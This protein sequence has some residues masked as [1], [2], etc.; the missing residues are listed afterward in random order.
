MHLKDNIVFV[1][2]LNRGRFPFSNSLLVKGL[3]KT[4]L[5]DVGAGFDVLIRLKDRVDLVVITHLHVDHFSLSYLFKGKKV[6]VPAVE[7]KYRKLVDLAYRYLSEEMVDT[8][9]DFVRRVVGAGDPYFTDVYKEG[10]VFDLGGIEVQP[11]HAPGHTA[12]HHVMLIDNDVVYGADIDLTSFGPWY[13]HVESSIEEFKKSI[14]RVMELKPKIYVSGHKAP[15]KGRRKIL[16]ELEKY[17]EKFDETRMKILKAL[18]EP[19]SLDE[20]VKMNLI[21]YRKPYA[22]KLLE[23]WEKNMILHHLKSLIKQNIVEKMKNEK[24]VAKIKA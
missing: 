24:Y 4:M 5:I 13:G 6:Y 18:K 16:E 11:I 21:Y 7:S 12:A 23:Y 1:E 22:P 17:A 20:L 10:D 19:K 2:G 14:R 8:W 9:L 3:R 15:I